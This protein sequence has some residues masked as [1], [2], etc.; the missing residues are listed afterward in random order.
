MGFNSGFKGLN[1]LNKTV[2]HQGYERHIVFSR[3]ACVHLQ[4]L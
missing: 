4:R 1:L 2:S 3:M